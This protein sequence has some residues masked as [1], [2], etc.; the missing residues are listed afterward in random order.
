M[1]AR[2]QNVSHSLSNTFEQPQTSVVQ[3]YQNYLSQPGVVD[4]ARSD[5]L[6]GPVEVAG[7]PQLVRW[8]ASALGRA[9]DDIARGRLGGHLRDHFQ[10]LASH[11]GR[12][13]F[14]KPSEVP[15]L[16]SRTIGEAR[17]A[18]SRH[19]DDL[20]AGRAVRSG[21]TEVVQQGDRLA[22]TR[23][24]DKAIGEEGETAL[25]V[26]VGKAGNVVTAYPVRTL[27]AGA[28][29]GISGLPQEQANAMYQRFDDRV[30]ATAEQV[31]QTNRRDGGGWLNEVVG[32]LDPTGI[33][34][35]EPGN[36]GEAAWLATRDGSTSAIADIEQ[37]INR[38][39][40]EPERR[41][42]AE[43]FTEAVRTAVGARGE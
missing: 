14:R 30:I 18:A 41:V 2:V 17:D 33:F 11:Q 1:N 24:F 37:S 34:Y 27:G 4:R 19:G 6:N 26:V 21:S 9:S 35:A 28:F 7:L 43:R 12:S 40:T 39:L 22:V 36:A 38:R 29:F 42:F 23:Q 15:D 13:I 10:R 31:R 25:R 3:N 8:G 5:V 16:L 32:I 20:A